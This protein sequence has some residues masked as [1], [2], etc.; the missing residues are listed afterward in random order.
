MG[1]IFGAHPSRSSRG[2]P[3]GADPGGAPGAPPAPRGLCDTATPECHRHQDTA[4]TNS[5]VPAAE[6]APAGLAGHQD[7]PNPRES[8]GKDRSDPR[9]PAHSSGGRRGDPEAPRY[10]FPGPRYAVPA[11]GTARDRHRGAASSMGGRLPER[12]NG[13]TPGPGHYFP[14]RAHRL[15]VPTAPA[16]SI[17]AR[18]RTDRPPPTPGPATYQLPPVM[19][20]RLVTKPSTPQC[21][22]TGRG[23]GIFDSE[24][25]TPGPNRYGTVDPNLYLA[26]APRCTLAG[27]GRPSP[28]PQTPGPSDYCPKQERR[29]GQSFGVRHAEC[30]VPVPDRCP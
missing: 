4:A 14:E 30:V 9:G 27:R 8:P 15:T 18:S 10:R 26:R 13:G 5:A 25:K 24:E 6:M 7:P 1:C 17:R 22:M 3:R 28:T 21:T 23:P 11:G 19:G 16:C 2:A 29:Q 12:G 20:P